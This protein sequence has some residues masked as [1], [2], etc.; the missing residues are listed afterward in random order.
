[1]IKILLTIFFLMN[2][3]CRQTTVSVVKTQYKHVSIYMYKWY[4][5]QR[6]IFHQY[7][8]SIRPRESTGDNVKLFNLD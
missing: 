5:M 2:V 4:T 3:F 6:I 1:M 7:K 8:Q